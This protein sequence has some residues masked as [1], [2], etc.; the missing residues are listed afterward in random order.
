MNV[1][2]GEPI[3]VE[4]FELNTKDLDIRAGMSSQLEWTIGPA[5]A[6]DHSVSFSSQDPSIATVDEN[7]VVTGISVGE[8]VITATTND[9]GLSDEC[10]VTITEGLPPCTPIWL[11]PVQP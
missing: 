10:V 6:Y 11:P 1:Y 8:T 3:P 7:G 5:V 2:A 4:T 9:G